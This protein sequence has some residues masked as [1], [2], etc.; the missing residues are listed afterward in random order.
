MQDAQLCN[1]DFDSDNQEAVRAVP[2]VCSGFAILLYGTGGRLFLY[3][4]SDK[5][6]KREQFICFGDE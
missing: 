6:N 1:Y 5:N 4:H 2:L 3:R